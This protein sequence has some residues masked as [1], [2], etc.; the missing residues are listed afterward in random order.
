M[1]IGT[2]TEKIEHVADIVSAEAATLV[3]GLKLAQKI[4]CNSVLVQMDNMVVVESLKFNTGHY[5]Q[6]PSSMIAVA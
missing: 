3:E 1:F 4:G 5:G 6:H 2:S